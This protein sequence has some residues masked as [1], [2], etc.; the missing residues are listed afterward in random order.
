MTAHKC[1]CCNYVFNSGE[2]GD[3]SICP[4]CMWE[5][6]PIQRED[7]NYYGG[8]NELSLNEYKNKWNTKNQN[9]EK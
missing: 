6:D 1:P 8:A 7:F 3:Y 5:D 2:A 4:I 9:I